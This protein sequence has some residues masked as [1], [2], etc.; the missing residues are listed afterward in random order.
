[1][2]R[3]RRAPERR[4]RRHEPDGVGQHERGSSERGARAGEPA[5]VREQQRAEQRRVLQ[6]RRAERGA[7]RR[8]PRRAHEGDGRGVRRARRRARLDEARPRRWSRKA[9][10]PSAA[11]QIAK[12]AGSKA[13]SACSKIGAWRHADGGV[14]YGARPRRRNEQPSETLRADVSG[15]TSSASS[16]SGDAR[17]SAARSAT[18]KARN[19]FRAPS[20]VLAASSPPRRT[21]RLTRCGGSCSAS[22]SWSAARS[23]S[24]GLPRGSRLAALCSRRRPARWVSPSGARRT[25]RAAPRR[26]SSARGAA[27]CEGAA[28]RRGCWTG[29]ARRARPS[30]ARV[31]TAPTR[32]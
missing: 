11:T 16:K 31:L 22:A 8:R 18:P 1:M 25:R 10:A 17:R 3:R 30:A 15:V 7:R 2:P 14:P 9:T 24:R 26:P 29:R 27:R 28:T 12:S 23:R 13:H 19:T 20:P 5:A 21:R 6:R 4:G 32:R